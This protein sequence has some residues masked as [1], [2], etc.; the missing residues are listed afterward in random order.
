MA[1]PTF[2]FPWR[3][4]RSQSKGRDTRALQL[5]LDELLQNTAG[6]RLQLM[7]LESLDEPQLETLNKKSERLGEEKGT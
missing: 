4:S 5:K 1:L 2:A 7:N 3:V 6:A